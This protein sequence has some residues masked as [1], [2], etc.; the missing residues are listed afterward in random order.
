MFKFVDVE[1]FLIVS[2]AQQLRDDIDLFNKCR[3]QALEI[4]MRYVPIDVSAPFPSKLL[5]PAAWI[6]SYIYV[7]T[8]SSIEKDE[9]TRYLNL[10]N[11][12]LNIIEK[13]KFI[14]KATSYLGTIDG[15]WQ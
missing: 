11:E 6:I 8:F 5:L 3:A 2:V 10:Y 7:N 4:I 15:V 1:P 14:S 9:H 12:A 13:D